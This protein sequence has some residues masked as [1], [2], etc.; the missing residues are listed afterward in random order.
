MDLALEKQ[1]QKTRNKKTSKHKTFHYYK[2]FFIGYPT[3]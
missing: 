3:N 2:I 1:K